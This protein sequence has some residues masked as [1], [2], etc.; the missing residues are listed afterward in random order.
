MGNNAHKTYFLVRHRVAQF[1]VKYPYVPKLLFIT[2]G[3]KQ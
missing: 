3:N 2:H 1:P